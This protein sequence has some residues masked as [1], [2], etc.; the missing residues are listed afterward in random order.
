MARYDSEP[1]SK[2]ST[3]AQRDWHLLVVDG[4]DAGRRY[5]LGP[6]ARV[7]R[8]ADS[9]VYLSDPQASRLHALIQE[10]DGDHVLADQGSRNGT[11]LRGMRLEG[12]ARL[13]D[14]DL[15]KIGNTLLKVVAPAAPPTYL[16]PS[17]SRPAGPPPASRPASLPP[18]GPPGEAVVGVVPLLERRKG[19]LGSESFTLVL[20]LERL[21]FAKMTSQMLK[22]IVAQAR[23]EAK[24]QGKGFFGQWGAQLK[25]YSTHA[26][27]YV[28]MPVEAI[29][30]EHPD[31]FQIPVSEVRTVRIKIG[32]SSFGDQ[33]QVEPD[34]IEIHAGNKMR[35]NLKGASAGEAKKRLRQV[36]GDRVK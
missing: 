11:F 3:A 36:L 9:D 31:N 6:R 10:L 27:H 20:T 25:A 8:S 13:C 23:Q 16:P 1:G 17:P 15:I 30:R 24:A 4:I 32:R 28:Q 2:G 34:R 7:G 35:F 5:R 29:L 18:S 12:P 14:G 26:Q 19:L 33:Q 21:I 22:D